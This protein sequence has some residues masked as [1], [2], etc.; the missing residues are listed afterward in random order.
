IPGIDGLLGH[1]NRRDVAEA[2]KA[3]GYRTGSIGKWHLGGKGFLPEQQ[4]FDV[5]VGGDARG[6]IG[7]FFGPFPMPGLETTT[8]DDYITDALTAAAERFIEESAAARQPFFLYLPHYTVHLP[9]SVPEPIAARYRAKFGDRPFPVAEYAAMVETFDRSL[10]RIRAKL[11][12]LGLARNTILFVTSDN[13][14]LRYEGSGKRLITDNSPLRAGKGHCYEGGIRDPLIVHWPGVTRPGAVYD[15]PVISPD[16]FPTILDMA[17]AAPARGLDGMS[18][19]P[20]LRTGRP[21]KREAVY[22]HYPHYSNQGGVPSGAV[23]KGD[24]KLIE[25]YEDGRVELYNLRTDVSERRNLANAESR[26][27]A[28]L[29]GLLRRWRAEVNATM[30]TS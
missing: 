25:F 23:R 2:L 24:W 9:L 10:G 20:L 1:T 12:A 30:P 29:L 15:A 7:S 5:N 17:G 19:A 3:A 28:E 14:G 13:G 27:A 26:R 6:G 22:W 8:K 16:F 21:P 11:D 4:G 18:L